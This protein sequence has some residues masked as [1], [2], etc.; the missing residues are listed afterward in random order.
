MTNTINK[1]LVQNASTFETIT[2]LTVDFEEGQTVSDR[3][4][5]Y[6]SNN[7]KWGIVSLE[8]DPMEEFLAI[9]LVASADGPDFMMDMATGEMEPLAAVPAPVENIIAD[10]ESTITFEFDEPVVVAPVAFTAPKT[11]VAPKARAKK[12]GDKQYEVLS[13]FICANPGVSRTLMFSDVGLLA[14]LRSPAA[15]AL[16][17]AGDKVETKRWNRRLNFLIRDMRRGGVNIKVE[18]QGRIASYTILGSTQLELPFTAVIE[19]R[20]STITG[21]NVSDEDLA[22]AT[23]IIPDTRRQEEP[24]DVMLGFEDLLAQLDE[25][26]ATVTSDDQV[27]FKAAREMIK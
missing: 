5:R 13:A 2:R 27:A 16:I 23:P 14:A 19:A 26:E 18:R 8:N 10:D 20:N 6:F 1:I 22:P 15:V 24:Q 9:L 25:D 21:I 17:N 3:I 4:D 7:S 11:T 12:A